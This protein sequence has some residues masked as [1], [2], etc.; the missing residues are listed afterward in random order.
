MDTSKIAFDLKEVEKDVLR[1]LN[2][3]DANAGALETFG[4]L[5]TGIENW[6]RLVKNKQ[7]S[8]YFIDMYIGSN[9]L[10]YCGELSEVKMSIKKWFKTISF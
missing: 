8:T 9:C 4:P 2:E 5:V 10:Q 1:M 3:L 6:V 7:Y